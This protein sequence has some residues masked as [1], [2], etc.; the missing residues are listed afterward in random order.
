MPGEC[1]RQLKNCVTIKKDWALFTS[2][3]LLTEGQRSV[4]TLEIALGYA[5]ETRTQLE[6]RRSNH[7]HSEIHFFSFIHRVNIHRDDAT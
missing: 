1:Y 6:I 3:D 5:T 2:R 4:A 7:D